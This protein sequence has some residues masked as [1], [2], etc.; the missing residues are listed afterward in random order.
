[1]QF[2]SA[3][4]KVDPK[5]STVFF[6]FFFLLSARITIHVKPDFTILSSPAGELTIFSI[7][8]WIYVD[9]NTTSL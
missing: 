6:F 3:D 1:M 8:V 9:T 7:L 5:G 4:K 2:M